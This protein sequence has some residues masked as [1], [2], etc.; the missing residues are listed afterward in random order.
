MIVHNVIIEIIRHYASHSYYG[1]QPY[2]GLSVVEEVLCLLEV[3]IMIM[4]ATTRATKAKLDRKPNT[5][6]N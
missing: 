2:T 3:N 4:E 5:Y 1:S 6:K